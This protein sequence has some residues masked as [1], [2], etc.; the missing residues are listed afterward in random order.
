MLFA[1][2]LFVSINSSKADVEV[3]TEFTVTSETHT[4]NTWS[5]ST[6]NLGNSTNFNTL[7]TG[8]SSFNYI[9]E[10]FTP[11][12]S[13]TYKMGQTQANTDTV[14][15]IYENSF[16]PINPSV[17]YLA[18]NDDGNS[19]LFPADVPRMCGSANWCPALQAAL[20]AGNDY[21][22]VI[23]T[24]S[25]GTV[26]TL[27]QTFFVTGEAAVGVGGAPPAGGS[28]LVLTGSGAGDDPIDMDSK[29]N[30][31]KFEAEDEVDV[32]LSF[33]A[34]TT[35]DTQG[36]S[37]VVSSAL[38]GTGKLIATGGGELKLLGNNTHAGT[39]IE[40]A[41]TLLVNSGSSL[42]DLANDLELDGGVLKA[43]GDF[44]LAHNLDISANDGTINTNGKEVTLSGNVSGAGCIIKDGTGKLIMTGLVANSLG[45]CVEQGVLALNGIITGGVV[46]EAGG[47]L[48][49]SG[50][51]QG[52][53]NVKGTLSPG[54][55]PDTLTS[56]GSVVQ[57][58][59]STLE[60]EVDGYGTAA[61]A[62]NYDR[63]LVTGGGSTFTADGELKAVLRGITAPANNTFTPVIGD[64]FDIV[65]ANGGIVGEFT[66]L[67]QPVTGLA[68]GT[69]FDIIYGNNIISLVVTP[70]SFGSLPNISLLGNVSNA[71]K[72][73]DAIRPAGAGAI[74]NADAKRLF[75]NLTP[76]GEAE[77]NKALRQISGEN[78]ANSV[79]VVGQAKAEAI[80]IVNNRL[81]SQRYGFN[82]ARTNQQASF[83]LSEQDNDLTKSLANNV[84]GLSDEGNLWGKLIGKFARTG[85]DSNALGYTSKTFG[86]VMGIDSKINAKTIA[87][88][89]FSNLNTSIDS[90]ENGTG[91]VES[92]QLSGYG[93]YLPAENVF[94]NSSLGASIE[95]YREARTVNLAGSTADTYGSSSGY[96]FVADIEAGKTFDSDWGILEPFAG[97]KLDWIRQNSF[98][99][100]G[101]AAVTMSFDANTFVA[102]QTRLGLRSAKKFE[103]NDL[104]YTFKG[105]LAWL[106]DIGTGY[107]DRSE[108]KLHNTT[109]NTYP[110]KPGKNAL[111]L[112]AGVM[113]GKED[114]LNFMFDYEAE[115][116]E[117]RTSHGLSLGVKYFW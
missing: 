9:V 17:N 80:K 64:K 67:T 98:T 14:M 83:A 4:V 102:P 112:G 47:I 10:Y 7:T 52:N 54:N 59:V 6:T 76:L 79:A 36:N 32:D 60:I 37:G 38:S 69:R 71:G 11:T 56:V 1:V 99:E 91:R 73:I 44:T 87:G 105:N 89:A 111:E 66:T 88:L 49:G 19:T 100:N 13:G 63:V 90:D 95:R 18:F 103:L 51:I 77:L 33:T 81:V 28:G 72:A 34:D 45:A 21:Y 94:I 8:G 70:T 104:D 12:T 3:T 41:T 15:V 93:S 29:N 62:G 115:L 106:R 39:L 85:S 108:V 84:L 5:L 96:S 74:T 31:V 116:R 24:Y 101:D 42:G 61:G 48:Q 23:S 57:G 78:K 2:S 20:T 30:S 25:S 53:I 40:S 22:I 97:L 75:D 55:S 113:F 43:D 58:P 82:M 16:D 109:F 117:N 110:A 92:W 114:G 27:P 46:V 35:F 50:T 65:E 68:T 26:L 86:V 107:Y